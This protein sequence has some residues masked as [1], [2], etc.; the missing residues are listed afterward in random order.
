[1]KG[2]GGGKG[3]S[4]S[5]SG[6]S[7]IDIALLQQAL[8]NATQA[9]HARYQQLGLG[10]PGGDPMNPH[11]AGPSTM[12]QQDVGAIPSQ[13]G[14]LP[15]IASSLAGQ[16]QMANLNNP[17]LQDQSGTLGALAGTIASA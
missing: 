7:P 16:T 13:Q 6:L 12:E 3:G 15:Q 11:Y 5:S 9:M 1:M 10:V 17:A 8:G 14:G 2:G 4:S